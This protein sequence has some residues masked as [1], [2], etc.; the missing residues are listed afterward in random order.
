MAVKKKERKEVFDLIK[1]GVMR[2]IP[3]LLALF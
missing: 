1:K 2:E 3:S